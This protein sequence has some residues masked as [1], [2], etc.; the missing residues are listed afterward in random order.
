MKRYI[1]TPSIGMGATRILEDAMDRAPHPYYA[2]ELASIAGISPDKA[3][4]WLQSNLAAEK[5]SARYVPHPT[6]RGRPMAEYWR[7]RERIADT[8]P[9]ADDMTDRT[10]TDIST[11]RRPVCWRD[12]QRTSWSVDENDTVTA[13]KG[14]SV[15]RFGK[16]EGCERTKEGMAIRIKDGPTLIFKRGGKR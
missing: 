4:G 12:G 1:T 5:V 3:R 2:A 13:M 14:A 15:V 11:G 7:G 8:F 16:M 6:G 9:E 10:D